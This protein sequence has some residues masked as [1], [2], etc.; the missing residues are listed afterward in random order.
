MR[1]AGLCVAVMPLLHPQIYTWMDA[2]LRELTDLVKE[3]NVHARN[4]SSRLSFALV[5]PDRRGINVIRQVCVVQC[6]LLACA[7]APTQLLAA[8]VAVSDCG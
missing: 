3:V 7:Q 5:Y 4:R 6:A 8:R 1:S 2:S